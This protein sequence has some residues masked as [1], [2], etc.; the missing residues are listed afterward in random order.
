MMV[1]SF[2]MTGYRV[3]LRSV[4]FAATSANCPAFISTG[5]TVFVCAQSV[6]KRVSGKGHRVI[7]RK[8]PP[9]IPAS[10]AR[11][12]A[13][14]AL[15]DISPAERIRISSSSVRYS[16]QDS[17]SV[18]LSWILPSRWSSALPMPVGLFGTGN[19]VSS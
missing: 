15:R 1:P 3:W 19:P 7:D 11:S 6:A 16:S 2:W 5:I 12:T 14:F 17:I 13:L 18:M 9:L 10:L 4:Y 8:S